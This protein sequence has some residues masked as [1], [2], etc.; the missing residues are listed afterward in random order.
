[1]ARVHGKDL[2]SLNVDDTGGTAISLL[3][4]TISLD[5]G[6]SGETH[7]TTTLG[8]DWREFT[9]GLKG[10]DEFTHNLFY[11]NVASTGSYVVYTRRLSDG[12]SA[13]LDFS[14]GVRTASMETIVTKVS[15]PINV[16]EMRKLSVTHKLTGAVTFS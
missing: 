12:N 15:D 1:L 9:A 4:D 2:T 3:D 16:A 13:T 7:D 10:G 14:D 6:V 8:D 5:F 11:D